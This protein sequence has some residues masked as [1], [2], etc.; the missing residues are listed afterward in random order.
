MTV[1][2][3]VR[4]TL[5]AFAVGATAC[6]PTPRSAA[7]AGGASPTVPPEVATLPY[8]AYVPAGPTRPTTALR[9]ASSTPGYNLYVPK[10][11]S[12][13]LL[14][15][16]A[17]H[18]VHRWANDAGQ[19]GPQLLPRVADF[20][21]GWQAVTLAPDLGL[22]A[23][24]GRRALLRLDASSRLL[25]QV[26]LPAHHDVAVRADGGAIVL[27]ERQR[28]VEN[29]GRTRLILDDE[30]VFVSSAGK[31]ERRVSLYDAFLRHPGLAGE[32][33]ERIDT[34]FRALD[35]QGVA[36]AMDGRGP[37]SAVRELLATGRFAGDPRE[38]LTLL[39]SLPGAPSDLFH[40]NSVAPLHRH[41]GGLWNDGDV[42]VCL[43]HWDMVA[44]ID[45][46]HGKVVWS[47]GP[48]VLEEPH[49]P[50]VLPEGHLMLLDNGTRSGRSRCIEVDLAAGAVVWSYEASPPS[51]FFTPSEGG[52]QPLPGGHVLVTDSSKGRAF[53][54]SRDRRIVW[55]YANP[56]LNAGGQRRSGIYRMIRVP[57]EALGAGRK[58]RASGAGSAN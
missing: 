36:A 9:S 38:A 55:E 12:A 1:P 2:S 7:P 48:G 39:R 31:V 46:V 50:S 57:P 33:K 35:E 42:L 8:V 43:R 41:P 4:Q 10:P 22:F 47:W 53:E 20:L 16:D 17:G 49:H 6:Q 32:M 37:I 28:L 44:A 56:I 27:A 19:P 29:L 26:D 54:V 13:A 3:R 5:L 23:I 40:T 18:V 45:P 30:I 52:C 58:T 25:W 14:V 15:D 34:R 11:Q 24:V 21:L 51:S